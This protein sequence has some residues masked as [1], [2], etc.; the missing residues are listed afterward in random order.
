MRPTPFVCGTAPLVS[1]THSVTRDT[2]N[3]VG[4]PIL[5]SS[6]LTLLHYEQAS[7]GAKLLWFFPFPDPDSKAKKKGG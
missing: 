6:P 2:A 4:R 7:Q 3:R 1:S 5:T